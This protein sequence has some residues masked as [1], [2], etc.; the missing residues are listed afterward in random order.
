[1]QGFLHIKI[2]LHRILRICGQKIAA[3][4]RC[5][6]NN[7]RIKGRVGMTAAH[8][9]NLR[10]SILQRIKTAPGA[11]NSVGRIQKQNRYSQASQKKQNKHKPLQKIF[12]FFPPVFSQKCPPLIL[13][14]LLSLLHH[15]QQHLSG[16]LQL[17]VRMIF[18]SIISLSVKWTF[19]VRLNSDAMDIIT[20]GSKIGADCDLHG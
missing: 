18:A 14:K 11:E 16:F 8:H 13:T 6:Q 2:G 4:S 12:S 1:M 20:F 17:I 15:L 5:P 19:Y 7:G 3:L 10:L 9:Q